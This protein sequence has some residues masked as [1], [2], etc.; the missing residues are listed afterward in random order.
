MK[1]SRV[2]CLLMLL[3]CCRDVDD[4]NRGR[5]KPRFESTFEGRADGL[6]R[7]KVTDVLTG[8]TYLVVSTSAG[9]VAITPLQSTPS[10]SNCP[11]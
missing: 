1:I 5:E 11:P 4:P 10:A 3:L 8:R 7:Y 2:S 6:A 9:G